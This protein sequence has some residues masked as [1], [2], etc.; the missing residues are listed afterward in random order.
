LIAAAVATCGCVR[1]RVIITS[2]PSGAEVIFRGRPRGV[3]PIEIP[4]KWHW[5]YD[6]AIDKEGFERIETIER[7][8]TP[9]WLIMPLDLIAE[10]LP[11]AITDT[12][13]LHYILRSNP[14]ATAPGAAPEGGESP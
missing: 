9:P 7:F 11:F 1:S 13:E 5:H 8:R 3:T 12:R 10:I 2:E 14:A 4:F 6:I